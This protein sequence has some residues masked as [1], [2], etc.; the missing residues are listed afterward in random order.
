[1]RFKNAPISVVLGR[2]SNPN[3][4]PVGK[5]KGD[6]WSKLGFPFSRGR[7]QVVSFMM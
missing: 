3:G 2:R 1:M 4:T 5:A 6:R 7:N